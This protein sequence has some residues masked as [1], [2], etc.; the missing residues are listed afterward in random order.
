MR[1]MGHSSVA[2]DSLVSLVYASSAVGLLSEKEILDILR[3]SRINNERLGITGMLLYKGGNFLQVLEGPEPAVLQL[4]DKI[5]RDP[6]H[7]GVMRLIKQGENERQFQDWSMGFRNLDEIPEE[8]KAGF[9]AY[10]TDSLLDEKFR[11]EPA[12]CYKLLRA[13]KQNFR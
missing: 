12:R 4:I 10:L 2:T 5:E 13:F 8:D 7:R 11:S 1:L 6:R 3:V 9:S